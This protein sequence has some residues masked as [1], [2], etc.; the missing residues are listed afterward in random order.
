MTSQAAE[1]LLSVRFALVGGCSLAHGAAVCA[2]VYILTYQYFDCTYEFYVRANCPGRRMSPGGR[3]E[4]YSGSE[5]H[6]PHG[7]HRSC[8]NHSY[9]EPNVMTE[10]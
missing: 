5:C 2:K 7:F 4:P 10:K 8:T 9:N 3:P 1:C 6:G